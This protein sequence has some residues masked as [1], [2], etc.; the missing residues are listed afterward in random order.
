MRALAA[1]LVVAV[2]AATPASAATLIASGVIQDFGGGALVDE[3]STSTADLYFYS[4]G[5]L[6][7]I[8]GTAG[9]DETWGVITDGGLSY[10]FTPGYFGDSA[11]VTAI[12][13]GYQI[14]FSLLYGDPPAHY[15]ESF[16]GLSDGYTEYHWFDYLGLQVVAQFTQGSIGQQYAI[17]DAPVEDPFDTSAT[18]RTSIM[19]AVPEPQTWAIMIVGLGLAGAQLRRRQA[20][21]FQGRSSSITNSVGNSAPA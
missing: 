15:D 6:T 3:V 16:D 4:T 20:A 21:M 9:Y 11:T 1:A 2:L 10:G 14:S 19:S 17:Y 13:G 5:T 8:S 12:A 7:S 18:A